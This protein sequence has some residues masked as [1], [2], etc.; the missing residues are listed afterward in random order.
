MPGSGS[1]GSRAGGGMLRG[2]EGGRKQQC[3]NH[4]VIVNTGWPGMNQRP[5]WPHR[6]ERRR[7]RNERQHAGRGGDG[8]L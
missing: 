4:I 6:E 5:M 1:G 7:R 3:S 8:G 2:K